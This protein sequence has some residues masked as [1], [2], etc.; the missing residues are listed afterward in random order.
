MSDCPV[1]R[2]HTLGYKVYSMLFNAEA[3]EEDYL[4]AAEL[5][6]NG[7]SH[8]APIVLHLDRFRR[9][10]PDGLSSDDED[11]DESKV[12]EVEEDGNPGVRG[13]RFVEAE[14]DH[15][16]DATSTVI[17]DTGFKRLVREVFEAPHP[18]FTSRFSSQ[19]AR[20]CSPTPS[21]TLLTKDMRAAYAVGHVT[22]KH[23]GFLNN[24]GGSLVDAQRDGHLGP[25]GRAAAKAAAKKRD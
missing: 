18:E 19:L 23:R 22:G 12:G 14:I 20:I 24:I 6:A 13:L 7:T 9:I 21:T 16:Q 3:A 1:L 4:R 5:H 11:D 25:E 8:L 17:N 2:R 15:Y 10:E